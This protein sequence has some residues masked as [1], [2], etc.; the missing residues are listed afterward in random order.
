MAP[1]PTVMLTR[2]DDGPSDPAGASWAWAAPAGAQHSS[3]AKTPADIDLNNLVVI[4]D[5]P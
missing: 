3:A 1:R 2:P 4:L 5:A